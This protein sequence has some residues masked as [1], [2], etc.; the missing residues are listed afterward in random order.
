M[1]TYY[2]ITEVR[3]EYYHHLTL[4]LTDEEVIVLQKLSDK[5][6]ACDHEEYMHSITLSFDKDPTVIGYGLYKND[7]CQYRY[8]EMGD[9]NETKD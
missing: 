5:L 2:I 4:D 3:S 8:N 1:T 6:N 7:L 9:D